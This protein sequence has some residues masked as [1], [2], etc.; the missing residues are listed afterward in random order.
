MAF[1]FPDAELLAEFGEAVTLNSQSKTAVFE[2]G[3]QSAFEVDTGQ[4]TL[5]VLDSDLTGI[6]RGMTAVVRAKNY[7]ITSIQPDGSGL[8]TLILE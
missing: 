4:P 8:S 1:S 2:D 6:T 5:L 3:H 7:V